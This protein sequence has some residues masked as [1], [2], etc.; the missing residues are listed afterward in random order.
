MKASHIQSKFYYLKK[1]KSLVVSN[2]NYQRRHIHWCSL[3]F[4]TKGASVPSHHIEGKSLWQIPAILMRVECHKWD[5][6]ATVTLITIECCGPN[7]YFMKR[8]E[9]Q[10]SQ[11][12]SGEEGKVTVFSFKVAPFTT[13]QLCSSSNCDGKSPASF[14]TLMHLLPCVSRWVEANSGSWVSDF[15]QL[16]QSA[17]GAQHQLLLLYT[18]AEWRLGGLVCVL[19]TPSRS[20]LKKGD[21]VILPVSSFFALAITFSHIRG[22]GGKEK[23]VTMMESKE[24]KGKKTSWGAMENGR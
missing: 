14:D 13:T 4:D 23:K 6:L 22:G 20:S 15:L 7:F 1:V 3:F 24:T 21:K 11:R 17:E 5:Y 10:Q 19:M 2:C 18:I 12:V 16:A 8:A 9:C